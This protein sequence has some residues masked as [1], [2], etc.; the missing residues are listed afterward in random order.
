MN[1]IS[2]MALL[3]VIREVLQGRDMSPMLFNNINDLITEI[4]T[5]DIAIICRDINE[6][7]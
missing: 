2:L 1:I 6:L 4:D 5:D 3:N 7:F